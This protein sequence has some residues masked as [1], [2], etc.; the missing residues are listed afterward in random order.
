MRKNWFSVAGLAAQTVGEKTREI[1]LRKSIG[2]KRTDIFWQFLTESICLCLC[3]GVLGIADGW[4]A[5]HGMAGLA[6]RIVPVVEAWPVVL[7]LPWMLTSVIF[8]IVM[9]VGFGVYPAMQAVRLSPVDALR[10]EH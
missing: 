5:A 7:S 6:V 3:G 2:A 10:T 4:G 1:G 9:G 8:S